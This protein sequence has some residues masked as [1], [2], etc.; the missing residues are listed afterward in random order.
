MFGAVDEFGFK[1]D[2]KIFY[3]CLSLIRLIRVF[4]ILFNLAHIFILLIKS[5]LSQFML[6]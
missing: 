2:T 6:F 4:K 1:Y 5:I 3:I